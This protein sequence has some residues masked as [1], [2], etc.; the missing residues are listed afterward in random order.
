M[1]LKWWTVRGVGPW[2]IVRAVAPP[3]WQGVLSYVY[4]CRVKPISWRLR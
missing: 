4:S 3:S 2:T 1:L